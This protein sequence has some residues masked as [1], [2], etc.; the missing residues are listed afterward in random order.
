V[1]DKGGGLT[2]PRSSAPKGASASASRSAP[3]PS[4]P[5]SACLTCAA[6]ACT[7]AADEGATAGASAA[8]S[9]LHE[10]SGSRAS[11][12]MVRQFAVAAAIVCRWAAAVRGW[13]G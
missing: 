8:T 3:S 13:V 4:P 9:K 2:F 6:A 5:R 10:A 1:F 12:S 7:S 11:T